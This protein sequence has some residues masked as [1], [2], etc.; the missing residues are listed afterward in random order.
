[1]LTEYFEAAMR[2]AIYRHVGAGRGEQER[3]YA[4]IH[5]I[6]G[7][8]ARGFTREE[9][10]RDLREALEWFVL[11]AVFEHR[12]LPR[13]D[14]ASLEIVEESK[15]GTVMVYPEAEQTAASFLDGMEPEA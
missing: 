9:A 7:I 5:G 2:H 14:N 15:S 11:T 10:E 1:M 6:S 8:W 3:V 12:P 4:A 13:Y